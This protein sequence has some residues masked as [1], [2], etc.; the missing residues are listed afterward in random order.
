MK[1]KFIIFHRQ[2]TSSN[3]KP[4]IKKSYSNLNQGKSDKPPTPEK[5]NP[6]TIRWKFELDDPIE[7]KKRVE[8]YKQ[9][10][11]SRYIDQ[12]NKQLKLHNGS[13]TSFLPYL[14]YET[15]APKPEEEEESIDEA[16]NVE[17]KEN[18][19]ETTLTRS[20]HR[21]SSANLSSRFEYEAK[22]SN[23]KNSDHNISST[24]IDTNTDGKQGACF[25]SDDTKLKE[26]CSNV[27][28]DS[29]I[30]SLSSSSR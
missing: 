29:A 28:T 7:E 18:I 16:I 24:L 11:R 4:I 10:R 8:I 12:R 14:Y 13:T 23:D 15:P 26:K 17:S 5:E 25:S 21:L 6:E 1:F 30:S 22:A 20:L 27:T 3:F 19:L 2:E 9:S